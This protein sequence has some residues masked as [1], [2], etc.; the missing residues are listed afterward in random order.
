MSNFAWSD[1][2]HLEMRVGRI[3]AAES[4]PQARKPSYA[5]RVDFGAELGIRRSVAAL[6][7]D[8]SIEALL[9]RDVIAVT[10]FAPRQVGKHLSEVL[11]LAAENSDGRLHLLAPDPGAELGSRIR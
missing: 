7:G 1:F 8:Y 2:E 9:G 5:L 10:N 11:I 6:A 4:F 3:V